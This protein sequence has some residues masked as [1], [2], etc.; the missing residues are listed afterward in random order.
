[1]FWNNNFCAIRAAGS[2]STPLPAPDL[3]VSG[4]VLAPLGTPIR[5]TLAIECKAI[6]SNRKY[7]P[8]K[9]IEELNLF[10]KKF[11]AEPY[12]AIRFDRKGWFFVRT[13]DMGF[14]KTN[15]YISFELAETKGKKF[16][17]I[18]Q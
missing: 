11:G 15:H 2:G 12:I 9:E 8:L 6:K 18:I 17:E 5:K 1:M 10:A 3:I 14:G 7:F 13:E 16:E 4:M